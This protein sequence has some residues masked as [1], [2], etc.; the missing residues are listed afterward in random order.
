VQPVTGAGPFGRQ[1]SPGLGHVPL[2]S[3]AEVPHS[4][5]MSILSTKTNIAPGVM[6]LMLNV[7][8]AVVVKNVP[9]HRAQDVWLT[10]NGGPGGP[11]G[12]DDPFT[13]ASMDPS[14]NV[15]RSSESVHCTPGGGEKGS[16]TV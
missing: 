2:H 14:L 7:A 11:S 3:G 8:E 13:L 12:T 5:R 15:A 10:L 1:T 4:H 6:F 16:V 9:A